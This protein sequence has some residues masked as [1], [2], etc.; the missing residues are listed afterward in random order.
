MSV[1]T[2][3]PPDL[4]VC[5]GMMS[6]G[7]LSN[8][9]AVQTHFTATLQHFWHSMTMRGIW[10]LFSIYC[11][12]WI[13][14]CARMWQIT[15]T[16]NASLTPSWQSDLLLLIIQSNNGDQ[17]F[18]HQHGSKKCPTAAFLMCHACL[19]HCSLRL[20]TRSFSPTFCSRQDFIYTNYKGDFWHH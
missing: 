14:L 11:K 1:L 7:M 8:T 6:P 13:W 15:G 2:K 18:A 16:T 19:P 12:C 3:D 9:K 17:Y 4:T 20:P 5:R 10:H